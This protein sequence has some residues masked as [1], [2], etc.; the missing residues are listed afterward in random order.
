MPL[1][2]GRTFHS[3]QTHYLRK[4]IAF[5]D[6]GLAAGV[7]VGTVPAGAAI[8]KT[9]L[10]TTTAWNGTVSVAAS[11]G[12]TPTGNDLIN[13]S[14]IRTAAARVDTVAPIAK[15][16]PS[17]TAETTVY[18]SVTFGGTAGSAGST[19]IVIPYVVNNDR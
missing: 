18:A 3:Q 9:T 16:I 13:A 4:T 15:A 8:D 7:V 11:V 2:Q 12:F 17:A 1:N 14:D 19:T 6:T 10:L 5:S